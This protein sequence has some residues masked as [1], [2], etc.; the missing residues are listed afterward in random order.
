MEIPQGMETAWKKRHLSSKERKCWSKMFKNKEPWVVVSPL[1]SS[2]VFIVEK[3]HFASV[4]RARKERSS[5]GHNKLRWVESQGSCLER[6]REE[7][8]ASN[9]E[10]VKICTLLQ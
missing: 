6:S 8:Q 9:V 7:I 10:A 2:F 4:C 3:R 5:E 1:Y